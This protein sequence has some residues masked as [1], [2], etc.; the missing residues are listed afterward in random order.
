VELCDDL[1]GRDE[2]RDL[3]GDAPR[4]LSEMTMGD[5]AR[6]ALVA[7]H[8]TTEL[9]D[10]IIGCTPEGY[11]HRFRGSIGYEKQQEC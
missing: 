3:M 6:S 8:G 5:W 11:G 9:M 7:R 2:A 10:E 1:L 4:W